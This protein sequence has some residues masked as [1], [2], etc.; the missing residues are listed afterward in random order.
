MPY[1]ISLCVYSLCY[2]GTKKYRPTTATADP[3]RTAVPFGGQTTWNLS[4]LS[5]KRHSSSK[6]GQPLIC[7]HKKR[8]IAAATVHASWG[9][10]AQ[11]GAPSCIARSRRHG[12]IMALCTRTAAGR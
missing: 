7:D 5:P 2:G 1:G 9:D 10:D 11:V 8:A 12:R 3:F 4:G 6:K